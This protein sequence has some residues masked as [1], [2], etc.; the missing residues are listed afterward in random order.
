M[1]R[2]AW[3]YADLAPDLR[4]DHE[5][6]IACLML[7]EHGDPK[8]RFATWTRSEALAHVRN[9]AAERRRAYE[10]ETGATK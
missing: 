7:D 3:S 5:E 6:H 1:S 2:A 9:L 10:H 8:P 4:T